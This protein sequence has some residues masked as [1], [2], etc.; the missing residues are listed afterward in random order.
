MQVLPRICSLTFKTPW[1]NLWGAYSWYPPQNWQI[2]TLK[3]DAWK[4]ILSFLGETT[5]LFW[6]WHFLSFPGGVSFFLPKLFYSLSPNMSQP[7][8]RLLKQIQNLIHLSFAYVFLLSHLG[9]ALKNK[10]TF[11]CFPPECLYPTSSIVDARVVSA[12]PAIAGRRFG[13]P[14]HRT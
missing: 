8:G 11:E 3:I 1:I 12:W 6:G 7:W 2:G 14:S 4:L 13:R 5:P 10:P 9:N